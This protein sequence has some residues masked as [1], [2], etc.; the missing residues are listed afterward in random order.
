LFDLRIG[1]SA[2]DRATVCPVHYM[3]VYDPHQRDSIAKIG[4][5][6]IFNYLLSIIDFPVSS[7]GSSMEEV[8]SGP[9]FPVR[10]LPDKVKVLL[11]MNFHSIWIPFGFFVFQAHMQNILK[12]KEGISS[13]PLYVKIQSRGITHSGIVIDCPGTIINTNISGLLQQ[14]AGCL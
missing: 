4:I 14:F 1:Y 2:A 9:E 12:T 3:F 11:L 10:D 8:S 5:I 13:A 6:Y 7:P